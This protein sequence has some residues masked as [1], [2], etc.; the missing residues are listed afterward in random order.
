MKYIHDC[1]CYL[2]NVK[3]KDE[4]K[5]VRTRRHRLKFNEIINYFIELEELS[6][7]IDDNKLSLESKIEVVNQMN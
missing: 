7:I 3:V 6:C 1:H 5:H 4:L 2:C